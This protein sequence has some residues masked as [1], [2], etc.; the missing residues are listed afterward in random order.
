ME[1]NQATF[2]FFLFVLGRNKIWCVE[3]HIY[4]KGMLDLNSIKQLLTKFKFVKKLPQ[5]SHIHT[6]QNFESII[7]ILHELLLP[8]IYCGGDM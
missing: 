4:A 1:D 7:G 6:N 2:H 3:D 8:Y 5:I